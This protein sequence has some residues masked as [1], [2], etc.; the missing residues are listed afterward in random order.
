M[1][2]NRN[3]FNA[4]LKALVLFGCCGARQSAYS[5][6]SLGARHWT[7]P[8]HLAVQFAGGAGLFA[9]GAGYTNRRGKGEAE[10]LYG[11]VPKAVGSITIHAFTGKVRWLP[12]KPLTLAGYHLKPLAL[13]IVVNYTLGKQYFLFSPKYYPFTYYGY[14]TALHGG[15]FVGS[16]LATKRKP[17]RK[18]RQWSLYYEITTFDVEAASYVRN[19][20]AM[21]LTDLMS[22]G[23]GVRASL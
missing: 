13:G 14:P 10:L 3:F 12:L 11:Y 2:S 8:D 20:R 15:I 17:E 18:I 19:P 5:Q 1:R 22:L 6:D 16:Q 4:F 23:I 21:K 7:T 9:I